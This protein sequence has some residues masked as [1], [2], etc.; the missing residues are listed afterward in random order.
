MLRKNRHLPAQAATLSINSV[1]CPE[2]AP[3]L[4]AVD[5]SAMIFPERPLYWAQVCNTADSVL[6]HLCRKDQEGTR[7]YTNVAR[8]L[9][10][11]AAE[12]DMEIR[13]VYYVQTIA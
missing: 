7:Y 11:S 10:R 4:I 13:D 12:R 6:E 1:P 8:N 3:G 9:L 2:C 5:P